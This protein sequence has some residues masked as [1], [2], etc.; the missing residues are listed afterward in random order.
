MAKSVFLHEKNIDSYYIVTSNRLSTIQLNQTCKQSFH[1]RDYIS[2]LIKLL[3][4]LYKF[5]Y[6]NMLLNRFNTMRPFL[7]DQERSHIM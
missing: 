5:R 1:H 2:F 6:H 7:F 3:R 4:K